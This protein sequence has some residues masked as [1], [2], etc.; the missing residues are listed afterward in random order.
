MTIIFYC[1]VRP[2]NE[3]WGVHY[4]S[5][6]KKEKQMVTWICQCLQI[7]VIEILFSLGNNF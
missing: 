6:D 5:L 4:W 7:A 3:D 1:V 2:C